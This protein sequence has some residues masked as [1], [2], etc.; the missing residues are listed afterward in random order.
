MYIITCL[1]V[2]IFD[3]MDRKGIY[4]L[5]GV[6]MGGEGVSKQRT[7]MSGDRFNILFIVGRSKT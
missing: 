4:F 1:S 5:S 7:F 3:N 6:W 2:N